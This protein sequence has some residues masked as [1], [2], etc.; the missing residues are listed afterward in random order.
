MQQGNSTLQSKVRFPVRAIYSVVALATIWQSSE[1]GQPARAQVVRAAN[2]AD[3]RSDLS[4]ALTAN[5]WNR[6]DQSIERALAWLAQQQVSG[7]SFPTIDSGQPAITALCVLAFL[8]SGEQPGVGPHGERMNRAIDFVLNCQLPSG[9]F[10][11]TSPQSRHVHQGASHTA[12]YNHAIA[13]LML[14]EVYGQVSRERSAQIEQAVNRALRMTSRIQIEPAKA[15]AVDRGGWRYLHRPGSFTPS[16]SDL[17]VTGWHLMFLRSAKNAQFDVPDQ[18][19][20]DAV[21]Y[22]ERCFDARQ[23]GFVYGLVGVDRYVSRG[24]MGV[25]ALSLSLGGKH[26]TEM[27]HRVGD[28]LLQNPFDTYGYTTNSHDRFHYSAYYCSNALAQLG[29]HYWR[30]GFPILARTL[31]DNQQP[32][33][34]WASESGEDRMY[35]SAYPTALSV[36]T[37]TPG[38]QLLPIYQR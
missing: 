35:G 12:T 36:L 3:I 1:V 4:D 28:W 37:L 26:Q 10:S 13:G 19:V 17:S 38:Y 2:P 11:Y 7:G 24:T 18:M 9:L 30:A 31:L 14:T 27:A 32:D 16:D 25:G 34:S 21:K 23:G 20:T 29:G 6:V 15:N 33:G 5:D 22:V 8:S